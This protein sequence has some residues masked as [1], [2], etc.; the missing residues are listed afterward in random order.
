MCFEDPSMSPV[1]ASPHLICPILQVPLAPEMQVR[2][3][4]SSNRMS[5]TDC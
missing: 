3:H 2:E 5:L 1:L 4:L